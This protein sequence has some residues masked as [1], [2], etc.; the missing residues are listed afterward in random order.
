MQG[1]ATDG[2]GCEGSLER[3]P[4]GTEFER[5]RGVFEGRLFVTHEFEK[6]E[7]LGGTTIRSM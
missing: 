6:T 4:E 1:R 5:P 3:R 7:G 2:S